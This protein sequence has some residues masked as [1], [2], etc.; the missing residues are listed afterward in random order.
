[1]DV[2]AAPDVPMRAS[3]R[4][5]SLRLWFYYLLCGAIHE[6]AH[7]VVAA[8]LFHRM[9]VVRIPDD[10]DTSSL[11]GVLYRT[12]LG[13]CFVVPYAIKEDGM[14][15]DDDQWQRAL[16]IIRHAGWIVSV[17]LV[18]L[19]EGYPLWCLCR[20]SRTKAH[21]DSEFRIAA[22]LTAL[23]AL[24]TDLL[25]LH[26]TLPL[27]PLPH[28]T[29]TFLCGNFG[30]IVLHHLWWTSN[31][32]KSAGSVWDLL[33]RMIQVTMIRGAQ[34]GGVIAYIPTKKERP[35]SPIP[36][37]AVR[38]RVVNGK[39]T[40]LANTLRHRV[41]REVW[42]AT[43]SL[44]SSSRNEHSFIPC[45][46][47]GH[48]R[49][50]TSSKATLD[51]THPHI[52]T[53][54]ARRRCYN[55]FAPVHAATGPVVTIQSVENYVTH[56]G[57]FDFFRTH[58]VTHDLQEVVQPWLEQVTHVPLPAPVDSVAIAG[59]VDVLR[60][61]GCFGLAIR[62]AIS[63]LSPRVS[64]ETMTNSNKL[65][66][67]P[68]Y[69]DLER[70][71]MVFEQALSDLLLSGKD[72]GTSAL[73]KTTG[74]LEAILDAPAA[75]FALAQA[76][77]LLLQQET[78][79]SLLP[80]LAPF[81]ALDARPEVDPEAGPSSTTDPLLTFCQVTI[82]AFLDNDL[83]F[84]TKT[85]LQNAKGSFGL[86]ISSSLD[87]HRQVCVAARG[88]TM[89]VAFYPNKGLICFGSEQASVKA[90]MNDRFMTV[91]ESPTLRHS[92]I[93][94]DAFRLDLDDFGGE[95]MCIDWSSRAGITS[96]A[97]VSQP[98]RGLACHKV[99]NGTID[100]VLFQQSK[101]TTQDP[102]IFH[103]MTRLSRN[104]FI[105]PLSEESEDLILTDIRD[106]PKVCRSIQDEWKSDRASSS[107]NRLT[108]YNLSRCL[109]KRLEAHVNGTVPPHAIDIVLTGCEVS[110]WLAEQFASDL[111]KSFP[112]LNIQA[113]SSNKLLG[114]YGQE[115][116]IPTLGFPYRHK[117]HHMHDAI[118]IIV[119][120]SGG[121][122]APLSCSN[123]LQVTG[124]FGCFYSFC[125]VC[126]I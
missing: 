91:D 124:L 114:L 125:R 95:V 69:A 63:G 48:T 51:G 14:E 75:R 19:V 98:H 122:F 80:P 56:N 10:D 72:G 66:A 30:I 112:G 8:I 27:L 104:R 6:M 26:H 99:M 77:V 23:E 81:V 37:R 101:A 28:T 34:S 58:G 4:M 43:P 103:R 22:A 123:L 57:D 94:H 54:K 64:P 17:A 2:M 59:V 92:D 85:F 25:R 38:T 15:D 121:T 67:F 110:L 100:L 120:H 83:F 79:G 82:D 46:L 13:R 32:M 44:C 3:H 39:R 31:S 11:W 84:A 89:S 113:V 74:T 18:L 9:D 60:A 20:T 29:T 49:F 55:L 21:G 65:V 35:N 118:V 33:E 90:A 52:W 117:A 102:Q 109:R 24:A 78:G 93:D 12:L 5:T 107:L 42:G 61:Q 7:A 119:S 70:I 45:T 97:P 105:K 126:S 108:A 16:T 41:E 106:I 116:A 53:P 87:A 36:V 86:C 88:Q 50:A 96:L 111:Q 62:Y 1:M 76:V 71:G 40:D 47:S 68:H 115:I 73:P